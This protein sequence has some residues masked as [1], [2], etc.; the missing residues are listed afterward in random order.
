MFVHHKHD[1][2][3][4]RETSGKGKKRHLPNKHQLESTEITSNGLFFILCDHYRSSAQILKQQII[5]SLDKFASPQALCPAWV[6]TPP[7]QQGEV[8]LHGVFKAILGVPSHLPLKNLK[9]GCR[10]RGSPLSDAPLVWYFKFSSFFF[11]ALSNRKRLQ[12]SRAGEAIIWVYS[13][14]LAMKKIPYKA[15]VGRD[16]HKNRLQWLGIQII[17]GIS[18][19]K[20]EQKSYT[21]LLP[22]L[23]IFH[24]AFGTVF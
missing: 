15:S 9:Q 14:G 4:G 19:F 6:E 3:K 21:V 12:V 8:T 13:V 23:L 5:L 1:G 2:W 11:L 24:T 17:N 7:G 22:L 16:S 10:H 20:G 18:P